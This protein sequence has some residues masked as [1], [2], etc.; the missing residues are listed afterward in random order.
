[1]STNPNLKRIV[2]K[3]LGGRALAN[4]SAS[5]LSEETGSNLIKLLVLSLEQG[6]SQYLSALF[7]HEK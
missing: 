3:D 6:G 2:L 5:W 7:V 1:M 4:K